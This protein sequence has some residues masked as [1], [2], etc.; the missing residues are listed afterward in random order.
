MILKIA[1]IG[2][3]RIGPPIRGDFA[4]DAAHKAAYV[5]W[6]TEQR[7]LK[8]EAKKAG[9]WQPLVDPS[10]YAEFMAPRGV[11]AKYWPWLVGGGLALMVM[12]RRRK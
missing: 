3:D 1:G 5:E 4:T 6:Y 9:L 8:E 12:R 11:L 10:G 7:R 2:Q